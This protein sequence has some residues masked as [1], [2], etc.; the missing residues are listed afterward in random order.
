MDIIKIFKVLHTKHIQFVLIGGLALSK[1][2][3]PRTSYD[4]D[5]AIKAIDIDAVAGCL[6]DLKMK[7][8]IDVTSKQTPITSNNLKNAHNFLENSKWGFMKFINKELEVDFLHDL[9]IPFMLL[10]KKSK[11]EKVDNVPVRIAS[12]EHLKIMKEKS[13][14]NRA[15]KQKAEIDKIDLAFIKRKLKETSQK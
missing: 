11:V 15:D 2:E 14:K 5:I 4:T 8:V 7:L 10:Y 3:S 6:F 13:S 12:L 9:P 1:Y